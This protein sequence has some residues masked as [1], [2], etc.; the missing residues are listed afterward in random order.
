MAKIRTSLLSPSPSGKIKTT[1]LPEGLITFSFKYLDLTH[2]KFQ[3]G[4]QESRYFETVL[5]RLKDVCA[6]NSIELF[7]NRSSSLRAHP[8]EWHD[9]SEPEGFSCLNNQL[10]DHPAY[11]F[12]ISSNEHGRVHGIFINTIFYIVWFDPNHKLYP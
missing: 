8:I 3:I 12:Q 1:N 2:K 9:T 11:Q 4:Q 10:R 5:R 7:S 6:Y